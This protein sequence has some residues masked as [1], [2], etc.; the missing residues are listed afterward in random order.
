[1]ARSFIG[2]VKCK[3][4]YALN[5]LFSA[6]LVF[7]NVSELKSSLCRDPLAVGA[8]HVDALFEYEVLFACI[9][10][11]LKRDNWSFLKKFE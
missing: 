8:F 2:C 1:M 9:P 10:T 6:K 7:S 5:W 11:G 3:R 4:C